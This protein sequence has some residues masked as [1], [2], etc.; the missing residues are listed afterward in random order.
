[1]PPEKMLVAALS[2][3]LSSALPFP[4]EI[5]FI[6]TLKNLHPQPL[7]MMVVAMLLPLVGVCAVFDHRDAFV[8]LVIIVA[9]VKVLLMPLPL[10]PQL[11]L[12]CCAPGGDKQKMM[13]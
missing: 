12:L 11:S 1:M 4:F 6:T 2:W 3:R 7:L 9:N 8:V 10:L 13:P 5:A